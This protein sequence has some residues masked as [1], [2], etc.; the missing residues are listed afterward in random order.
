MSTA[1]PVSVN[2]VEPSFTST[3]IESDLQSSSGE[4]AKVTGHFLKAK[5]PSVY[6][7]PCQNEFQEISG[8]AF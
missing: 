1:T 8:T 4:L 2:K 7:L 3:T 5:V 6:R